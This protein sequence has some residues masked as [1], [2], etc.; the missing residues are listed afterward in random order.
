[1]VRG[2]TREELE[3][4]GGLSDQTIEEILKRQNEK[5]KRRY[6]YI[7]MLTTAEAERLAEQE[8]KEFVRA[9]EWKGKPR[10]Q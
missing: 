1:M 4:V 2:L 8:G 7:V 3:A 5:R 9:T 10:R 6:R